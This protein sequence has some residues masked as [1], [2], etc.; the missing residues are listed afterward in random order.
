LRDRSLIIGAV[1]E[2]DYE[3]VQLMRYSRHL[4]I[5]IVALAA[6]GTIVVCP[7][8]A[9]AQHAQK[10]TLETLFGQYLVSANGR[11]FPKA[12]GVMKESVSAAAGYSLYNGDGTG[13]DYVTFT[14]DGVN[15]NVTSDSYE[16]HPEP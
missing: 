10:C 6:T 8:S 14:V 2:D 12:F 15:Q 11:L 4:A 9:D 5:A 7:L 13:T 3:G 16:V 1:T